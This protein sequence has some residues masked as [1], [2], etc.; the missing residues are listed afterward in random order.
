M[1]IGTKP[2]DTVN[3][4]WN[5]RS[6]AYPTLDN[7][8]PFNGDIP[9]LSGA[10]ISQEHTI[11]E[12]ID[13][14]LFIDTFITLPVV[15]SV[16]TTDTGTA[17]VA[18]VSTRRDSAVLY[19]KDTNGVFDVTGEL[20]INEVDFVGFYTEESTY[21]ESTSIGGYWMF[22]TGFSYSNNSVYY[23]SGRGMVYA[24]VK[25]QGSVRTTND[26]YNIQNTVGAIG[27]YVTNK[28]NSSYIENLSYR[29]DPSAADAQDGV[30]ADQ[31][32]NKFV[33]RVGTE[34]SDTLSVG[35]AT[36]MRLYNLDNRVIDLPGA[37]LSYDILN[38]QQTIVDLWDGYIAVSYTH[39]TLPT[40]M[41]V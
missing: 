41:I 16:V 33:V 40:K 15:G 13:S 29:G 12:K 8:L 1:Y 39:L 17:V 27:T 22:N 18:Y 9:E 34:Y 14:I 30:E 4:F 6:F 28:N 3:L 23:D 25:P 21:S 10:F 20:F 19:L 37:G 24:D 35:Y 38:K 26:Y 31:L 5:Q 36:E 32:S 7:F 2:N 11:V